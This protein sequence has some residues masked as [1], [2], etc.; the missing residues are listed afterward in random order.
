[1]EVHPISDCGSENDSEWSCIRLLAESQ[2]V[3][4]GGN[5][6][7]QA[8]PAG[9]KVRRTSI[10]AWSWPPT[11]KWAWG[12]AA[13]WAGRPAAGAGEWPS[14]SSFF[15]RFAGEFFFAQVEKRLRQT[16]IER[17]LE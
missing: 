6:I 1:M 11:A 9:N 17:P 14:L 15:G 8:G 5:Q 7:R 3:C 13:E 2:T 10:A 4:D 12:A 16:E